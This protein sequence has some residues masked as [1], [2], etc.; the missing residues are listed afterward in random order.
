MGD[1]FKI[2]IYSM[3]VQLVG[4]VAGLYC[5]Y[6]VFGRRTM[7]LIGTGGAVISMVGPALGATIAPDTPEAAKTFLAFLFLYVIVY[8][9]FAGSMTWPISAEVVNSRLRVVTLSFATGVDYFFAC[10]CIRFN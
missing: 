9:G 2:S 5:A 10:K 7:L 6:R 8:C 1:V 3:V 4:V